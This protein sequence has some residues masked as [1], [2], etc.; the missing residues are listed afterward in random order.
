MPG[1]GLCF[2]SILPFWQNPINTNSAASKFSWNHHNFQLR[3]FKRCISKIYFFCKTAYC[4][5]S[6]QSVGN[7]SIYLIISHGNIKSKVHDPGICKSWM[8]VLKSAF[9]IGCQY[10]FWTDIFF[11]FFLLNQRLLKVVYV[12]YFFYHRMV[13]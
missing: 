11:Y 13:S 4:K 5:A 3:P 6:F 7:E 12:F 1:T 10:N 8:S 2:T 9:N